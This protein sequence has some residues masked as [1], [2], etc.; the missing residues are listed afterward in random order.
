[1]VGGLSWGYIFTKERLTNKNTPL[2]AKGKHFYN[3][4]V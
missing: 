1:M 4:T 2:C 3:A